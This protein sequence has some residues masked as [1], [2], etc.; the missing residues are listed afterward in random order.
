MFT[1]Q[2]KQELK[3]FFCNNSNIV[4]IALVVI[5]LALGITQVVKEVLKD[6]KKGIEKND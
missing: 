5:G 6:L 4:P 3:D 1:E 2:E